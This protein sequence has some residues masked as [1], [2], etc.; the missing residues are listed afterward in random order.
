MSN[1]DKSLTAKKPRLKSQWR[2]V[3]RK[4]AR[5]VALLSVVIVVSIVIG[6]AF[7]GI[8]TADWD[9]RQSQAA[10]EQCSDGHRLL[11]TYY[12]SDASF[13][14]HKLSMRI[15][16]AYSED[17]GGYI[18]ADTCVSDDMFATLFRSARLAALSDQSI[19]S[20]RAAIR[21][22]ER[23]KQEAVENEAADEL[24]RNVDA[25]AGNDKKA[26]DLIVN[27]YLD[28][29][30]ASSV[31]VFASR[32]SDMYADHWSYDALATSRSTLMATI[33]MLGASM[34]GFYGGFPPQYPTESPYYSE[35]GVYSTESVAPSPEQNVFVN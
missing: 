9:I 29:D 25:L 14:E 19:E 2:S 5:R 17:N 24:Q 32:A 33:E 13:E 30:S 15:V 7:I 22:D 26:I 11:D 28:F 12:D 16:Q 27:A 23:A 6:F 20:F 10:S 31:G 4:F 35:G 8:Q 3:V 21:N 1:P 34:D 18:S